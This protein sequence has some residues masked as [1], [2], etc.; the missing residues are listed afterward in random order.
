MTPLHILQLA[1]PPIPDWR[2]MLALQR[3][4]LGLRGMPWG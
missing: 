2:L 4:G 1:P 3:A